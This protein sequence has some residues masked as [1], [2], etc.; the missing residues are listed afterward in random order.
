MTDIIEAWLLSFECGRKWFNTIS[1]ARTKEMYSKCLK[2]YCDAVEKT[3]DELLKARALR[4][5]CSYLAI[6]KLTLL[7]RF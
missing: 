4:R 5:Y 2:Q 6:L 1:S 3:P 7:L